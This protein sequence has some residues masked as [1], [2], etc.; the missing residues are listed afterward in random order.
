MSS[1]QPPLSRPRFVLGLNDTTFAFSG[2]AILLLSAVFWSARGPNVEK[3]DFSLT[4]VGA[5]IVH[6]GRG[7]ELYDLNLQKQ[8]RNSLYQHPVPLLLEHPPFEALL[9]SPL[10]GASF[11]TAY[12]IWGLANAAILA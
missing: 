9:L 4:F 3:T 1:D 8:I 5:K 2:V 6:D 12:L 7:R 10:A 11:R